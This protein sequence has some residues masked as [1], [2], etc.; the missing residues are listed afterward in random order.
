MSLAALCM[1]LGVQSYVML[2][3]M[4]ALGG[5]AVGLYE[6][7]KDAIAADLLPREVRG[8][9]FGVM[10]VVTG[11]GDLLSSVTVGW[12]WAGFGASI[13]FGVALGLMLA[14]AA[15]MLHLARKRPNPNGSVGT[16]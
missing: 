3:L 10:A 8:S 7:V 1:I 6:A 16:V 4:F 13:A 11:T 14:G 15:F 2:A 12:L 5:S 9:G